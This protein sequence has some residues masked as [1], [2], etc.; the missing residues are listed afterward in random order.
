MIE[1]RQDADAAAQEHM[2]MFDRNKG[3]PDYHLNKL[4]LNSFLKTRKA[5]RYDLVNFFRDPTSFDDRVWRTFEI[6]REL[7]DE[8]VGK[9]MEKQ[10]EI[11]GKAPAYFLVGVEAITKT[12]PPTETEAAQVLAAT[13]KIASRL[14]QLHK[15]LRPGKHSGRKSGFIQ[16]RV[17]AIA[18]EHSGKLTSEQ[19]KLIVGITVQFN[20]V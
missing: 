18:K 19:K 10:A 1:E 14:K 2:G 17:A 13:G 9:N 6:A 5:I 4:F 8:S 7:I 11:L 3:T 12:R 16:R 20:D 15:T